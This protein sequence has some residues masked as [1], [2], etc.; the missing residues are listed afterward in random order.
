MKGDEFRGELSLNEA[1]QRELRERLS[2]VTAGFQKEAHDIATGLTI[3]SSLESF[4]T[5]AGRRNGG[6]NSQ[7]AA[8]LSRDRRPTLS[9]PGL[10]S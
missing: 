5:S 2:H 10:G 6:E 3:L 1:A 4:G 8:V 7:S 9:D